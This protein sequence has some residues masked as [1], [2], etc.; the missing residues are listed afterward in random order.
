[1]DLPGRSVRVQKSRRNRHQRLKPLDGLSRMRW[2]TSI[3]ELARFLQVSPEEQI[4]A[5]ERNG[6]NLSEAVTHDQDIKGY[7]HST[8]GGV[9]LEE[10]LTEIL[11]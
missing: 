9:K 3:L 4:A 5:E 6:S 1:M 11:D 2:S 8:S 7:G 10:H